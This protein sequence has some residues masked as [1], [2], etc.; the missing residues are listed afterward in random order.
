VISSTGYVAYFKFESGPPAFRSM[1]EPVVAFSDDGEAMI[2]EEHTGQLRA[3][4]S[5]T[6]FISVRL[7]PG[8]F[9]AVVPGGD[10]VA[11]VTYQD[12][13]EER[14]RV[15]GFGIGADG[16][17]E[18]LIVYG[19]DEIMPIRQAL[20]DGPNFEYQLWLVER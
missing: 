14:R 10:W 2:L 12:G 6:D 5:Y 11:D 16:F 13:V 4:S 3:A 9:V 17:G 1:E 8:P 20:H 7:A 15:V 18:P 19:G